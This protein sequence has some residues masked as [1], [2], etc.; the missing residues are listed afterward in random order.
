MADEPQIMAQMKLV[1]PFTSQPIINCL[2]VHQDEFCILEP[3]LRKL[4]CRV[5][6]HMLGVNLKYQVEN[7][8]GFFE[9][10][11]KYAC[12]LTLNVLAY[13]VSVLEQLSPIHPMAFHHTRTLTCF[14][15]GHLRLGGTSS[16]AADANPEGVNR[17]EVSSLVL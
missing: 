10:R 3:H 15:C 7:N 17:Q 14:S 1:Q 13:S 4:L 9:S 16:I 11:I 5:F 12:C 2:S 8:W 6:A